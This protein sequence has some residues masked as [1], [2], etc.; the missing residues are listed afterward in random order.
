MILSNIDMATILLVLVL[1]HFLTGIFIFAYSWKHNRSKSINIFLISKLFQLIGWG[2]LGMRGIIPDIVLISVG[3]SSLFIGMSMELTALMILKNFYTERVKRN[4]KTML[5]FFIVVFSFFAAHVLPE[6]VRIASATL[7][8][9]VL[10]VFPVFKLITDKE[11]SGLQRV[12][13]VLYILI[14]IFAVF[15]SVAALTIDVDINMMSKKI[16]NTWLFLL[17]YIA[18]ITGS[19]GFVLLDKE[20]QDAELLRAASFDGLTN[21]LNRRTFIIRSR[22]IISLCVRRQEHISFLLIDIDDFK[23]VNDEHGHFTGDIVLQDFA[24][25]IKNQLREY[26]LFGRYG[27]EEFAILLPG[28]DEENVEEVAERLRLTAENSYAGSVIKIK[29]TIS[30]GFLSILPDDKTDVDNL[31]KL[32]DQ[33][34]YLAKSQGKNCSRRADIPS[35]EN[36]GGTN[37]RKQI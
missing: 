14:I 18:M 12:T 4:Y 7:I 32:C 27:G 24:N 11:A 10:M 29:Y 28:V 20:K 8:L 16:Y 19:I 1:G 25:I 17:L 22:E 3:N 31:Y 2:I 36:H 26:D 37:E 23:K 34:L 33:A 35:R 9:V 30:I 6:N 5:I 13:S 15:R 21:I